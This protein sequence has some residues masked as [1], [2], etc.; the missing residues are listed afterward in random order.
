MV[1]TFYVHNK[2]FSEQRIKNWS[3]PKATSKALVPGPKQLERTTYDS[4]P[5]LRSFSFTLNYSLEQHGSWDQEMARGEGRGKLRITA[6]I[7]LQ[8]ILFRSFIN[9]QENYRTE[10]EN[11]FKKY[12]QSVY[13][14]PKEFIF[15]PWHIGFP[16]LP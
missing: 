8:L 12:F 14:S 15:T 5:F 7:F 2:D 13:F 9:N 4:F 11:L 16:L 6:T 10:F 3:K 1:I